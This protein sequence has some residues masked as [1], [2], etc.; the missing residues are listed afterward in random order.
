MTIRIAARGLAAAGL[1]GLLA[2]SFLLLLGASPAHAQL[3]DLDPGDLLDPELEDPELEDPEL[4]D[5]NLEEPEDTDLIGDLLGEGLLDPDDLLELGD[6]LDLD[7]DELLGLELDEVLELLNLEDLDDLLALLDEDP[8]PDPEPVPAPTLTPPLPAA[9]VTEVP[10]G[11]V[12]T[13]AGGASETTGTSSA[14]VML[15]SLLLVGVT[16]G[17]IAA[18]RWFPG[19]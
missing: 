12:A 14:P 19:L 9:Q 10:R 15:A 17:Q 2:L 13:G 11:G 16:G 3:T 7:S 5:P 1:A 6:L 18:R 4:E 8:A